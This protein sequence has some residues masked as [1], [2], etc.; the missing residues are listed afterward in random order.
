[1]TRWYELIASNRLA[2]ARLHVALEAPAIDDFRVKA[3]IR[4]DTKTRQLAA[5]QKLVDGRRIH[6]QVRRKLPHRHHAR[7]IVFWFCHVYLSDPANPRSSPL[8]SRQG[9][10][11][12][13]AVRLCRCITPLLTPS[14]VSKIAIAGQEGYFEIST[15]SSRHINRYDSLK[16][17]SLLGQLNLYLGINYFSTD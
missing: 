12:V 7:Q 17:L 1:M 16:L 4:A 13:F 6:T 2:V 11:S 8:T 3:P 10:A 14:S 5:A 9:L 15:D